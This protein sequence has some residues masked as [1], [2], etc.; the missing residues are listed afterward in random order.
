MFKQLVILTLL[1]LM[2]FLIQC[3]H[4]KDAKQAFQNNNYQKTIVLCEQAVKADSSD[5]QALT[6]MARSYRKLKKFPKALQIIVRAKKI[7]PESVAVKKEALSI[8]LDYGLKFSLEKENEKAYRQFISAFYL[9]STHQEVLIH[10]A[11]L[12]MALGHLERAESLYEKLIEKN[13]KSAN[14]HEKM[15]EIGNRK[16]K[17]QGFYEK[18]LVHYKKN[19]LKSTKMD[20]DKALKT[21]QDHRDA[22]YLYFLTEGRLFLKKGSKNK[23]WDAIELFGKAMTLKNDLPEPHFY[24]AQCYEKKD[25]EFVNAID[26]YQKALDLDPSGRLAPTCKKKIQALKKRKDKLDKFWGRKK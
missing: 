16:S 1:I 17:A 8:H 11:D 25:D 6:L 18:A 13:S 15:E 7:N 5:I 14:W 10:L 20:L 9:D 26:E 4:L 24:M 2:F 3:G 23:L 12:S 22:Q 19:Q 21:N